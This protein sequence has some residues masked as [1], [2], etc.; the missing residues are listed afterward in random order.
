VNQIDLVPTISMLLGVPVPFANL[1]SLVP[2]LVPLKN[3]EKKTTHTQQVALGLALNSAQ[4]KKYLSTYSKIASL[5]SKEVT[6]MEEVLKD[7]V[8]KY[9][10]AIQGGEGKDSIAYR[11]A[12]ALFKIFL[13]GITDLGRKVSLL[14]LLL[15]AFFCRL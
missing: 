11:E 13:A 12:C 7:A 4:V 9:E 6:E 2:A 10:E 1:G 5:P 14:W 8:A 3:T 15:R